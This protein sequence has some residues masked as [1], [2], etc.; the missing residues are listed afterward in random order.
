VSCS[1]EAGTAERHV[2]ADGASGPFLQVTAAG[3]ADLNVVPGPVDGGAAVKVR[4]AGPVQYEIG[5]LGVAG[6]GRPDAL[7]R[8]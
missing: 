5:R 3:G 8:R 4:A 7:A 1:A 6:G 2:A